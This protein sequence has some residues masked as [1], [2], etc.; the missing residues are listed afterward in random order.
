MKAL[1]AV[2]M[3]Q[4]TPATLRAIEVG[5][6]FL[7]ARDLAKADYPCTERVNSS[8]FA[9]SFPLSFRSD[10]LETML[11]LTSLGYGDDPRLANARRFILGKRD[12][13]GRWSME[14]SLNGKMWVEVEEK[15]QPSKWITQR[16]LLALG[17]SPVESSG[18][19]SSA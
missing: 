19:D 8:W 13:R 5:V 12:D 7:L 9:F 3:E 6:D 17:L 18:A 4:R 10:V 16:A 1:T 2:P 11:V 14:K 15:G